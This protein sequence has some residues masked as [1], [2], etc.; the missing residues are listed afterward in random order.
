MA[1]RIASG[2]FQCVEPRPSVNRR[3]RTGGDAC[4]ERID[5]GGEVVVRR[6]CDPFGVDAALRVRQ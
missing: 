3:R 5:L 1:A 6:E 2:E 4:Q